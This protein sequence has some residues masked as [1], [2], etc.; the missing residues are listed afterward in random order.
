MEKRFLP[1]AAADVQVEDRGDD[2]RVISGYA[3]VYFKE[4]SKAG[5]T[6]QIG[7][8]YQERIMPGAFDRALSERQ[9][10][11][12]TF[13]HD[14]NTLLGRTPNTLKLT[15]DAKGLRY[16]IPVDESDP[17]HLRVQAK[18]K[19]GDIPGSSFSFIAREERFVQGKA[20]KP[21]VREVEDV[22][23]FDVGP[24]TRPA[25]KGTSAGIRDDS[26]AADALAARD[27]ARQAEQDKIELNAREKATRARVV[28][29]LAAE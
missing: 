6:Y 11:T 29:I 7:P 14:G 22:D 3:A 18:L 9:D 12:G 16:E 4:R 25:Y 20:G 13:N 15:T 27:K 2:G 5:T 23:L 28:E 17:D 19:R 8:D 26:D 1:Q 24:V 10:V 21:D